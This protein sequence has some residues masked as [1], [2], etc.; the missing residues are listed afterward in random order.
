MSSSSQ[1]TFCLEVAVPEGRQR[2]GVQG[3][4]GEG[5]EGK[6]KDGG[7]GRVLMGRR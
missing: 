5:W 4:E 1:V 7:W 2:V 6:R 3:R